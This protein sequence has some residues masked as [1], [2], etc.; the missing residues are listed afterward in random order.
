M[1]ALV[2]MTHLALKMEA[3]SL[4]AIIVTCYYINLEMFHSLL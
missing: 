1:I 2:H 4:L 3:E